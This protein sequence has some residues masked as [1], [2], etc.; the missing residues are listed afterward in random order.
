[1]EK[2]WLRGMT[3]SDYGRQICLS[4]TAGQQAAGRRAHGI[5]SPSLPASAKLKTVLTLRRRGMAE[6]IAT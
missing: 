4:G 1:V 6:D 3:L 2:C 5:F